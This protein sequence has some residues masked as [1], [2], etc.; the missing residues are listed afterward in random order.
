MEQIIFG[1]DGIRDIAGKWPINATGAQKIGIGLGNF[2]N[3]TKSKDPVSVLIGRDTRNSGD[4][5]LSS[6]A[7]GL[8][9]T[10]VDV[11]DV[12]VITTAAVAYLTKRHSVNI[13]IMI[14]AS[15]NPWRENGI[16]LIGGDGHKLPDQTEKAVEH[17]INNATIA[18]D[19]SRSFGSLVAKLDWRNEYI[20]YLVDPFKVD[21][22]E[23]LKIVI[24]C[25]NGAASHIA[26]ECFEMLNIDLLVLNNSP[27]GKNINKNSGSEV[28][29]DGSSDLPALVRKTKAHLGLAFDGDADRIVV[30]AENG[31]LLDGDHI[32][33]ILA[34]YLKN[35]GS[36]SNNTIVTTSM[37]NSGLDEALSQLG[38]KT[39]RTN[40]G[41]KYVLHEMRK[42]NYELGGEQSGHI[43]LYDADHTTGDGIY[44]ALFLLRILAKTKSL[45][46]H[47]LA[48]GLEK[49]PQVIAS[50]GMSSKP[51]P[52]KFDNFRK[53][54]EET[55]EVLGNDGKIE[56]RYSGTEY[57]FRVM[58]EGSVQSSV[59]D[60]AK[61]AIR[62][63]RLLQKETG[64]LSQMIEIKDCASGAEI[65][66][67]KL[68]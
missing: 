17:S 8:L 31:E 68:N 53:G 29:R 38:I 7:S 58:I 49:R 14:S 33:Y 57:L 4:M 16:K 60:I 55:T 63:C 22:L 13:G 1:T 30:I 47:E 5:L 25:A 34:N 64:D 20:K 41:D 62:L 32:L 21:E 27:T 54:Y 11:Y 19:E 35:I 37:A 15:H 45:A 52:F 65:D 12:G 51:D 44:T 18:E 6:L 28:V 39:I 43:I 36:L 67:S 2:L 26:P 56:V 40:V 23:R 48:L 66:Q 24:D 10:G 3:K 59:D 42:S 9:A 46:I 61:Q 50:A